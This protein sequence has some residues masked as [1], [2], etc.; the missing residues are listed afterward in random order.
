MKW[1][2]SLSYLKKEYLVNTEKCNLFRIK[3]EIKN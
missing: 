2:W 1:A 3:V